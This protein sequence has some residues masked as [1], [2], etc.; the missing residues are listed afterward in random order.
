MDSLKL[1][2]YA[3]DEVHPHLS[4]LLDSLNKVCLPG[5][6]YRVLSLPTMLGA[7]G[8]RC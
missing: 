4:D 2:M 6:H 7:A 8:R 1:E 3:V 5:V